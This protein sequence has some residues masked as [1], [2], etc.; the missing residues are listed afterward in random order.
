MHKLQEEQVR[1]MTSLDGNDWLVLKMRYRDRRTVPQI[2]QT[3]GLDAKPLYA[4]I[5]RLLGRVRARLERAGLGGD[6]AMT[7]ATASAR[8]IDLDGV[9]TGSAA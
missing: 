6:Q 5:R 1:A 9:F 7:L 3:L 8:E 4:R 2:A